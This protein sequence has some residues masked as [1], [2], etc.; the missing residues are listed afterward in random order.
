MNWDDEK[1]DAIYM[2]EIMQKY[3]DQ[4]LIIHGV[5]KSFYCDYNSY[6]NL[7][8]CT[9]QCNKCIEFERANKQ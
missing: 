6:L 7:E 8:K 2:S 5:S 4:Q 1:R 3:A 9:E